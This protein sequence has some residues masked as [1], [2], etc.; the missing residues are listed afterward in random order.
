MIPL[1]DKG[2]NSVP[3]IEK[4]IELKFSLPKKMDYAIGQLG[5]NLTVTRHKVW[6]TI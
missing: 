6:E 3:P 2:S 1:F 4:Y 5:Y